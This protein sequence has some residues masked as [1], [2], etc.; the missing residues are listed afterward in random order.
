MQGILP[1]RDNVNL[2]ANH[3]LKIVEKALKQKIEELD[4]ELLSSKSY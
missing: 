1:W 4:S 3:L 2:I